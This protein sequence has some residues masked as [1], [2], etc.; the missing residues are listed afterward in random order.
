MKLG[1]ELYVISVDPPAKS[2]AQVVQA[3]GIQFPVLADQNRQT[4]R[5]YGVDGGIFAIPSAFVIDK[6]GII[7]YKSIG[8][9]S[10][11][12][13]ID[14]LIEQ[15]E[16]LNLESLRTFSLTLPSGPSLFHL[17]NV[18]TKVNGES[19]RITKVSD[20]FEVLGG[21]TTSTG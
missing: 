13:N 9:T 1:A 17:P 6:S 12:V 21:E 2:K 3:L 11:R 10:H 16:T 20:L 18:V 19:R 7:R 15:L 5:A 14:T 4:I 8:N